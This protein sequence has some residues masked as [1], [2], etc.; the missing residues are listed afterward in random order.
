MVRKEIAF[1]QKGGRLVQERTAVTLG[2]NDLVYV[3]EI[4]PAGKM[5]WVYAVSVYNGDDV[6]RPIMLLIVDSTN[7]T[8]HELSYKASLAAGDDCGFPSHENITPAGSE[9]KIPMPF[10]IKAGN[11]IQFQFHGGGAS[12]GGTGYLMLTYLEVDM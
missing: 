5:W 9:G 4:V 8:I 11:K 10:P 7:A 1:T 2:N 3:R 12:A 6:A